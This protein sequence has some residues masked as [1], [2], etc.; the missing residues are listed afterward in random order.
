MELFTWRKSSKKKEK[1]AM[2]SICSF[3]FVFIV[4]ICMLTVSLKPRAALAETCEKWVA[5]VVSA[6]GTVEA[7]REGETE[8]QAVELNGTYCPGD[9]IRVDKRSRADIALVNQPV[10]RLDQN[11][12]ITLGGLKDE[13]T[14]LIDLLGGAAHFFS[15]VARNLEVRTAFVN[16]GVEG[17]EFFI[18]VD[19]D[20]TSISI[21]EGKV[22]ASNEAGSLAVTSGQSAE[23]GRGR[24]GESTG[25]E[26]C[27]APQGRGPMGVVFSARHILPSSRFSGFSR[28]G[29]AKDGPKV[30][31]CILDGRSHRGFFRH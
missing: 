16:A 27:G 26:G 23:A 22:L 30:H 2:K 13:Q 24:G 12:T 18:R 31:R 9:T 11:T 7:R 25:L 4:C 21:F 10:I 8:W 14:S 6:Q 5:K 3:F 20:K 1:S 15:R 19:E 17:T 28:N 29:L